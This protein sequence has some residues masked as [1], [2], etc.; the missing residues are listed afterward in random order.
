M[1]S[2]KAV[3]RLNGLSCLSFGLLFA[4]YPVWVA[5]FLGDMP[6]PF[7]IG[8]GA[9]LLINAAHLLIAAQRNSPR[10]GEILWFSLGDLLWW[11]MSIILLV[12]EIWITTHWGIVATWA[13]AVGVATMG[14]LQ[15]AHL[16]KERF[17]HPDRYIARIIGS[18][19]A[20]PLWVRLWLVVLNLA[21]LAATLFIPSDLARIV[22]TAFV[23]TGPFLFAMV[24]FQAGFTRLLGIAH[25]I[26]WIPLAVW[27]ATFVR[28]GEGSDGPTAYAGVLLA[29][30]FVCLAFDV[31]DAV[32]WLRG[33]RSISEK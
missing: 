22:L 5:A 10:Q 17:G 8:V 18:W 26:C 11:G 15:F 20:L 13:V 25:L 24:L 28:S 4:F 31:A 27:L 32:R 9:G 16:G 14:L 30:V 19:M 6:V 29:I 33:E 7:L 23:A 3:L 1:T 21:F 2:M 12:Q